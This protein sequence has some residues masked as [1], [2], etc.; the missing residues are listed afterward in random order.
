MKK[1]AG[2]ILCCIM[3]V[4]SYVVIHANVDNNDSA[5]PHSIFQEGVLRTIDRE[6]FVVCVQNFS[7]KEKMSDND[8]LNTVK[9][10]VMKYNTDVRWTNA[11]YND[12]TIEFKTGCTFTPLLLEPNMKHPVFGGINDPQSVRK[13][14]KPSIEPLGIFIVDEEVVK[15]H[16]T[17]LPT[18]WVPEQFA[19]EEGIGCEEVTKGIYLTTEEFK[20][21]DEN[22]LH[23]ELAYGLSIASV[24]H[25]FVDD[26]E[27]NK[28]LE[29]SRKERENWE[30]EKD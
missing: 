21:L 26:P 24:F 27:Y 19:C 22:R 14:T 11:G 16:F 20:N 4:A 7:S 15:E 13:V 9:N 2:I 28:I 6:N 1:A 29:Q 10:E 12:L 17:G 5:H 18:R 25:S 8:L 3:L 30:A 23:K